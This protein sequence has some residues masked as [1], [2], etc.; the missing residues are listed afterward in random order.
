MH[1]LIVAL[2][3]G[4]IAEG[5]LAEVIDPPPPAP[6]SVVVPVQNRALAAGAQPDAGQ[7]DD[8]AVDNV[9]YAG[10]VYY[11]D[12]VSGSDN[13]DGRAA[14]RAWKTVAQVNT[15]TNVGYWDTVAPNASTVPANHTP[16]A[17]APSGS[18]FLFKRGCN[19]DGFVNVHGYISFTNGVN[20][21]ANNIT[22]GAYG[23]RNQARP[24]IQYQTASAKFQGAAVWANGHTV[25][26]KNLRLLGGPLG[27]AGGLSLN[28]TSNVVIENS[29]IENFGL[30]GILADNV[31]NLLVKNTSIINTQTSGG[32]GGGLAGSGSNIQVLYSTFINNGR[33]QVGAHNIYLRHLTNATIQG[34]LLRGG[35]NLGIVVHGS[36]SGVSIVRNDIDGNSNGIDVTGGYPSESEVF[37]NFVIS[38]NLIHGNGY[39]TGEQ[40]YGMLIKSM[41]NSVIA[42]NIVYGNRLGSL[43]FADGNVGDPPSSAV[44]I[45]HN[46]IVEPATSGGLQFSGAAMGPINFRNNIV[47]TQSTAPQALF[48]NVNVPVGA[49]AMAGNLYYAPQIAANRVLKIANVTYSV[50]AAITAGREANSVY[51]NPLFTNQASADFTIPVN[52]PA[53]SAAPL[54]TLNTVSVITDYAGTARAV[55][56]SIGAY[57]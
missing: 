29:T 9:S 15:K 23:V 26:V 37:D 46:T 51:G 8:P 50:P 19:F 14:N 40:G 10:Q 27:D 17:A 21:F 35:S 2:V 41:T 31:T 34:N 42:N 4:F 11:V 45:I 1:R 48:V 56:P 30:D 53:K 5:G 22:L 28:G 7:T 55:R 33:D 52:S 39:R 16:W 6:A 36:S 54:T 13:N 18:A 20:V 43:M 38:E 3:V 47:S 12:C 25:S 32:R 44:Q 24:V 49:L 57:E